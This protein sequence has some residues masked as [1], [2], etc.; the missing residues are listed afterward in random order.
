MAS[1][2]NAS[3]IMAK[4]I[5]LINELI[6][7]TKNDF[8]TCF[9][10]LVNGLYAIYPEKQYKIAAVH[11]LLAGDKIEMSGVVDWYA[12]NLLEQSG[13][14]LALSLETAITEK[15]SGLFIL[16]GVTAKAF[17]FRD[18]STAHRASLNDRSHALIVENLP[19]MFIWAQMLDEISHSRQDLATLDNIIAKSYN[20][21]RNWKERRVREERVL[22]LS[23][24]QENCQHMLPGGQK[25]TLFPETSTAISPITVTLIK[26]IVYQIGL[27]STILNME[28]FNTMVGKATD[29][30]IK[31]TSEQLRDFFIAVGIQRYIVTGGVIGDVAERSK[32]DVV[33]EPKSMDEFESEKA[34]PGR[35]VGEAA[36]RI[37]VIRFNPSADEL[38][39]YRA[40]Q[41][42]RVGKNAAGEDVVVI[43][44]ASQDEHD[45]E[46]SKNITLTETDDP[47]LAAH[48]RAFG[49]IEVTVPM[50]TYT[51]E[52]P[53]EIT[54]EAIAALTAHGCRTNIGY[55]VLDAVKLAKELEASEIAK[56]VMVMVM[57]QIRS[58]PSD[59]EPIDR[60]I[61]TFNT[62]SAQLSTEPRYKDF[63]LRDVFIAIMVYAKN[64]PVVKNNPKLY[65]VIERV[66]QF[67]ANYKPPTEEERLALAKAAEDGRF[68]AS[69]L[70]EVKD[71]VM[72]TM[73]ASGNS[74]EHHKALVNQCFKCFVDFK[75]K[76]LDPSELSDIVKMASRDGFFRT[77]VALAM[78]AGVPT[79]QS[80]APA[81]SSVTIPVQQPEVVRQRRINA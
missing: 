29:E 80:I 2:T 37:P 21:Q 38:P 59:V 46:M 34:K 50:I 3:E 23:N 12:K 10:S 24:L 47:K 77:D 79:P 30:K 72:M 22:S 1:T 75:N 60:A 25:D 63:S 53:E 51:T 49:Y 42:C 61:Q 41:G 58:L 16:P 48:N 45:A 7:R 36:R 9:S 64:E 70:D 11:A 32:L 78:I 40:R 69:D 76:N 56:E 52:I 55:R 18:P 4:K 73:D 20:R 17:M 13:T 35:T 31:L 66:Q 54:D 44:I 15:D 27:N 26:L 57:K 19:R 68:D 5:G 43:P 33:F 6:K 28:Y 81:T 8:A 65:A 14:I 39:I 67:A 71:I 74:D 62:L